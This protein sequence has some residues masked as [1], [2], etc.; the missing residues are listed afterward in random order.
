MSKN[1]GPSITPL[2]ASLWHAVEHWRFGKVV[3][4]I[5]QPDLCFALGQAPS[6]EH[7]LDGAVHWLL[8]LIANSTFLMAA[9]AVIVALNSVPLSRNSS[10][11]YQGK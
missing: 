6:N 7:S 5:A 11:L 10:F 8:L 1:A 9:I 2:G 4:R 3:M